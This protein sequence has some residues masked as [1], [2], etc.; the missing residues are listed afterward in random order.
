MGNKI[1]LAS[2]L[3][4]RLHCLS[5]RHAMGIWLVP[6]DRARRG[7]SNDV[8]FEAPGLINTFRFGGSSGLIWLI[9]ARVVDTLLHHR[10]RKFFWHA[11]PLFLFSVNTKH[12]ASKSGN[13]STW[14]WFSHALSRLRLWFYFH[15]EISARETQSAA[16]KILLLALGPNL[17]NFMLGISALWT[18]HQM[19]SARYINDQTKN[20][21]PPSS[22][23][24]FSHTHHTSDSFQNSNS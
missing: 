9:S 10:Y 21:C 12:R 20:N 6:V 11:N 15:L 5:Y 14:T 2:E 1:C 13:T 23:P 16:Q 8:V 18:L 4:A 7:Q 17:G 24:S 22:F 19:Y 3:T